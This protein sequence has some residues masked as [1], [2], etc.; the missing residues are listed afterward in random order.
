[1]KN[2]ISKRY[3]R[4]IIREEEHV[5]FY[6]EK[7]KEMGVKLPKPVEAAAIFAGFVSGKA[8]DLMS[9]KD[10]YKLGIAVEN[11]AV[12][13]YETFIKMADTDPQLADLTD[14]LWYFMLDE[15]MHQYW[16]QEYLSRLEKYND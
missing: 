11:K 15:E 12:D 14:H 2:R 5:N 1:M 7:L 4:F 8:L 13:M 10:Q 6:Y 3:E 16:F 9:L